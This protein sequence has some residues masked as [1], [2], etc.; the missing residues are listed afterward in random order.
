[1]YFCDILYKGLC[2]TLWS[3][4]DPVL[5]CV[6][7]TGYTDDVH[8]TIYWLWATKCITDIH[9]SNAQ[10]KRFVSSLKDKPA[11]KF[12]DLFHKIVVTMI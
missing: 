7:L 3:V 6:L 10:I 4:A 8:H 5:H 2:L 12:G 11:V 9:P 1:M